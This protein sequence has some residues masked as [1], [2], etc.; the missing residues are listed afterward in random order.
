LNISNKLGVST[1]EVSYETSFKSA[2]VNSLDMVEIIVDAEKEF[3][4][5]VPDSW[6]LKFQSV[7]I[8][9]DYMDTSLNGKLKK[10]RIN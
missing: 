8:L 7:G 3:N 5:N 1:S 9:V 2:G 4:I 10:R 6:L